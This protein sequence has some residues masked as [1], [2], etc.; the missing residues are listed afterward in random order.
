M[1]LR[2]N[3]RRSIPLVVNLSLIFPE[4]LCLIQRTGIYFLTTFAKPII[5]T[6][7]Q[8]NPILS[9]QIGRSANHGRQKSQLCCFSEE[10]AA[11]VFCIIHFCHSFQRLLFSV[12]KMA[13]SIFIIFARTG[14]ALF[15]FSKGS[16][17]WLQ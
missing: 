13:I 12:R 15:P 17:P 14:F 16:N 11:C 2:I 7:N 4:L 1:L 3:R 6:A 8:F 10:F 9:Q 5:G